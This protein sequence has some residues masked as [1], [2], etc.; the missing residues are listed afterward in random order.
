M[1]FSRAL[2]VAYFQVFSHRRYHI[3]QQYSWT[4]K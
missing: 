4:R 2:G 1:H 3:D